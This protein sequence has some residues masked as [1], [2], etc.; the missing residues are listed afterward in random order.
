MKTYRLKIN[1]REYTVEISS[2][3]A[4]HAEVCVNGTDYHVDIADAGEHRETGDRPAVI[5][6]KD[7]QAPKEVSSEAGYTVT[8]PLPGIVVEI[9]VE[10]GQNVKAGQKVAVL[11]AMKME[12]DIIAEHDGTVGSIEVAKGDSVLEGA[13]I[14]RMKTNHTKKDSYA[15]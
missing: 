11:E 7:I 1:G 2:A 9:C 5:P 4:R 10:K 6:S 8:S 13:V 15:E 3:D 14:V 12:N